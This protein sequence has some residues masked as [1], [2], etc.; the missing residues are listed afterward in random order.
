MQCRG[1]AIFKG[2]EFLSFKTK[3]TAF[4]NQNQKFVQYEIFLKDEFLSKILEMASSKNQQN[5]LK[6]EIVKI[7]NPLKVA[8]CKKLLKGRV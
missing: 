5:S 7:K 3:M 1:S 4:L 6:E 8:N 2:S